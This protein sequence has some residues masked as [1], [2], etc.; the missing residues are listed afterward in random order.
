MHGSGGA[1][2]QVQGTVAVAPDG[3]IAALV[4]AR[5]ALTWQLV[6]PA[7][8]AVVRERNWVSFAPG[9]VRV[10]AACHGINTVSQTGAPPPDNEPMAL[11]EL[12]EQ[13]SP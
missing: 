5:R 4:P 7:G 13:W 9:E 12:L 3:S 1:E 2:E 6:G 11:L 8:E 10:C